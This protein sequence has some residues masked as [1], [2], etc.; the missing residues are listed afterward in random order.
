MM[1]ERQA[2]A[3]LSAVSDNEQILKRVLDRGAIAIAK[4]WNL[5]LNVLDGLPSDTRFVIPGDLEWPTQL[6]DL[7]APPVG[8]YVRGNGDLRMI[9]I[10]SV[11]IV[12]SRASSG[13]GNRVASELATD[14]GD[15]GW[16]VIS[17]AAFGID[18]AAHRGALA[19]DG[20][21]AAV[22]AHGVD[23]VYP[24]A[25]H[26]LGE[27]IMQEGVLV[28]EVPPGVHPTRS[29]FLTRNRLIAA[30]TRGTVV[31]EAAVRSGSLRTAAQAESLMR[32]VMAIPGP[33]DS[34]SSAGVHRWIADRRAELVTSAK[35]I[36]ELVGPLEPTLDF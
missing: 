27:R 18:A 12:G 21:T 2:R 1:S 8:L 17:G 36:I 24:R 25:H 9:A 11:A 30:L 16:A 6:N 19:A 29:R 10:S 5:P 28:S 15:R 33:I 34:P 23:V 13:Y 3:A 22:L 32:V 7:D 35:E 20:L 26:D 14:L 4:E 31:V